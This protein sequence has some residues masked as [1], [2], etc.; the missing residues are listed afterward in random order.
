MRGA[1]WGW[2]DS[3]AFS[4]VNVSQPGGAMERKR[5]Y[6]VN[7]RVERE[8]VTTLREEAASRKI[9]LSALIREILWSSPRVP[10]GPRG[11]ASAS[12]VQESAPPSSQGP[13]GPPSAR[14]PGEGQRS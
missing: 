1:E 9:S 14:D 3:T 13:P 6:P 12:S 5:L 4:A 8:L 11:E 2:D 7:I 10:K